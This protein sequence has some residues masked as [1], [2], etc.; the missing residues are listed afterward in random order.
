[1][2]GG[3][4][5]ATGQIFST[6]GTANISGVNI[7]MALMTA[8][9]TLQAN[10]DITIG[11]DLSTATTNSLTLQAGRSILN[12]EGTFQILLN[13]GNFTAIFNDNGAASS[14]EAASFIASGTTIRLTNGN[15]A[16]RQG[17]LNNFFQGKSFLMVLLLM[18]ELVL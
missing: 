11:D 7:S 8:N 16:I 15:V 5:P 12:S 1:M 18:L 3:A 2:A 4:D 13:G 17:N 14:A 9:L 6:T 10:Q